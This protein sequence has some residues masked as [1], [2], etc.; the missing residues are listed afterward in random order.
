MKPWR[1]LTTEEKIE[2]HASGEELLVWW[3][4]ALTATVL[5]ILIYLVAA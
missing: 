5:G 2:R 3:L 1:D 4:L